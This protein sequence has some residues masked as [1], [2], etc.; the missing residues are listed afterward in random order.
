MYVL[1]IK[2][3]LYKWA[4]FVFYF[5]LPLYYISFSMK[6]IISKILQ[7]SALICITLGVLL[8]IGGEKSTWFAIGCLSMVV[9]IILAYIKRWINNG[10][11]DD[12][13]LDD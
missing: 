7:A 1:H 11:D 4:F 2:S 9:G 12:S 5:L 8:T 10:E 13:I 3:S 6:D